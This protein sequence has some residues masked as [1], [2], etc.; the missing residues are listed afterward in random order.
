MASKVTPSGC[1]DHCLPDSR[2]TSLPKSND[3]L[4]MLT[5]CTFD[6][7]QRP[8]NGP[9]LD[10]CEAAAREPT[11]VASGDTASLASVIAATS[12]SNPP[13]GLPAPAP[14]QHD[15]GLAGRRRRLER[16]IRPVKSWLRPADGDT[17][18]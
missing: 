5:F 13:V 12:A 2:N 11:G 6:T 3:S 1:K 18:R 4:P 15:V 16:R 8:S 10:E 17:R 14:R 9:G 7:C